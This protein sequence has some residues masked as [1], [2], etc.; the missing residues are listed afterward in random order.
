MSELS[1]SEKA[2]FRVAV[3]LDDPTERDAFVAQA[4]RDNL[5]L[6]QNLRRLLAA[7]ELAD[8][9]LSTPAQVSKSFHKVA[10]EYPSERIGRYKILE[11]IGE[12]GFGIVYMA[13]QQT[14]V[15]RKVA[16]KIIKP[17]MDSK[18]VIARFESERQALA[19]MD[20][21]NIASV[22]DA[23]ET[24]SGR[25]YFVMELVRGLPITEYADEHCLS[26]RERLRFVRG[27]L[28]SHSSCTPKRDH[29]PRRQADQHLGN[30][31]R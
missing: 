8:G 15:V 7:D 1:E 31:T 25:P 17:G 5:E 13:E 28:F 3:S 6:L 11:Q 10:A 26:T 4:C 20:H 24:D 18:Q 29:S 22:L 27:R 14:P 2:I 12:G 16:L 23:G 21:P 30:H 19:L 9:L